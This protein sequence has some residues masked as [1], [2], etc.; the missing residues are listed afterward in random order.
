MGAFLGL[1]SRQTQSRECD[2]QLRISKTG[3]SY[4]RRLLVQAVQYVLK[5]FGPD[6]ELRRWG[7]CG[8]TRR[9]GLVDNRLTKLVLG[10]A[11][12]EL[13]LAVEFGTPHRGFS[14]WPR[15]ARPV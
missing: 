4:L 3:N 12:L 6:S 8:L 10:K 2:P 11:E 5:R 7:R 14:G 15:N 9:R 1:R 13:E